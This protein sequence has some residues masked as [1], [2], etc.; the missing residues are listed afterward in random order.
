MGF[1]YDLEGGSSNYK[2]KIIRAV[3]VSR[4]KDNMLFIWFDG[5]YTWIVLW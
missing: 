4:G 5:N 2:L 1:V 3:K